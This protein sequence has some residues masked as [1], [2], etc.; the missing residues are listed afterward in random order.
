AIVGIRSMREIENR[1]VKEEMSGKF[2]GGGTR[3]YDAIRASGLPAIIIPGIHAMSENIDYRMR[4]FSHCASPEKVGIAYYIHKRGYDDFIF[5][6][7]SSNTVTVAVAKRKIIGGI[8]ACIFAPGLYQ[9]PIDLQLIR[10]IE[11]GE[12]GANEAFSSAGVLN[13]NFPASKNQKLDI[14]SLFAAMEIAAMQIL[15][16]DYGVKG[17]VFLTGSVGEKEGVRRRISEHLGVKC[18]AIT[19]YSAAIGCAEIAKDVFYG[20]KDILGVGVKYE[21]EC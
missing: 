11:R 6:D 9:G 5:C 3:V 2:V 10:S 1:G 21:H 17:E 14:I 8:D 16:R 12:I 13:K 15:L 4:F 19:H 7:I 18:K 20:R